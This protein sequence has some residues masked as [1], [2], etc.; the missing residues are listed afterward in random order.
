MK[1]KAWD[2]KRKR[3]ADWV[4]VYGDG[5]FT[6]GYLL[7]GGGLIRANWKDADEFG[8]DF[9]CLKDAVLAYSI[10]IYDKN[11]REVFEGD[12]IEVSKEHEY[13]C[14]GNRL[15][16]DDVFDFYLWDGDQDGCVSDAVE[17][18]VV[19]GNIYENPELIK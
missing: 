5:T 9:D 4:E 7:E 2:K 11:K 16:I 14:N 8:V 15:Y 3:W 1:F 10:G 17:A 19:I 18:G 12:V 13:I 6:I